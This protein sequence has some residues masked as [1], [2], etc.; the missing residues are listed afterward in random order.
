MWF[1]LFSI[2]LQILKTLCVCLWGKSL[3]EEGMD[4]GS[5]CGRVGSA[6]SSA[7]LHINR[8]GREA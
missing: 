4:G 3:R 7:Y 1:V 6:L 2:E 8:S 5:Y